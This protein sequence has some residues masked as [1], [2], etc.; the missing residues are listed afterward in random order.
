MPDQNVAKTI[1]RQIGNQA[2]TMMGAS[3]LVSDQNSLTF[4]VGRNA[5]GVTHVVVRLNAHDYYDVEF[6]R[7]SM[8]AKEM[9]S[10]KAY[11]EDVPVDALHAILEAE[12]G[13]YLSL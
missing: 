3:N 1:A 13:L 6:V 11:R 5:K 2:L 10:V 9:R 4:K 8:R 12:T 7:F